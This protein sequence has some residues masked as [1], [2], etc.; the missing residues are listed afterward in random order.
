MSFASDWKVNLACI[1]T[2]FAVKPIFAAW[3]VT[4]R[5][6]AHCKFCSFWKNEIDVARELTVDDYA[7]AVPRLL[8]MGVRVVNFAGGEPCIREDLPEIMRL[9]TKDFI[10]IINSNGNFIDETWARNIWEA[11][12][13]VVNISLDFFDAAKHD[14][15]RGDGAH[16]R[17]VE[18]MR[19]LNAAK[20]KKCQKVAMQAILSPMNIDEFERMVQLA[21]DLG[22]DFSFNPYRFGD[23]EVDMSFAG[24]DASFIYDLKR[25]Y[26]SFTATPGALAQTLEFIKRGEVGVCGMGKYMLAIDPYGNVGPCENMMQRGAGNLL[27]TPPQTLLANLIQIHRVNTCNK[28]LTRERSEV[29]PLYK[30]I[31]SPT[32]WKESFAVKKG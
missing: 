22:V 21:E 17:A 14:Y 25:K 24:A 11:G 10:V 31:G 12:V 6:N 29:E 19:A 26:K 18:A 30:N 4:Y 16:R 27:T 20:T 3:H 15:H 7:K 8:A 23:H 13:D 9:F 28:C 1:K 32:W 2:I 5:C